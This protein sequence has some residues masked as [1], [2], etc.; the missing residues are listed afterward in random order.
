MLI[1]P[2]SFGEKKD[3]KDAKLRE[4]CDAAK[5]GKFILYYLQL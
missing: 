3:K 1:F 5:I 2:Q 4:T